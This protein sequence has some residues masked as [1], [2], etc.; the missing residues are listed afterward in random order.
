MIEAQVVQSL[1]EER[2]VQYLVTP[3]DAFLFVALLLCIA[4][5]GGELIQFWIKQTWQGR[6]LL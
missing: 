4:G 1:T 2:T 6:G 3:E 5:L